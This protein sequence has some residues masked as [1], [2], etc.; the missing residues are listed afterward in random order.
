MFFNGEKFIFIAI[1][2]ARPVVIEADV[3]LLFRFSNVLYFAKF[4]LEEIYNKFTF[5]VG[6]M[7]Y[8]IR[9]TSG[10]A[11]EFVSK[12]YLTTT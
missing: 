2:D 9:F 4:A 5:A 1:F 11:F 10:Y 8:F 3:E 12:V 7:K 6:F